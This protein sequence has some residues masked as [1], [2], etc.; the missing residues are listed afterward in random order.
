M[1]EQALGQV[2]RSDSWAGKGELWINPFR[3]NRVGRLDLLPQIDRAIDRFLRFAPV[4]AALFPDMPRTGEIMSSLLPW[5]GSI[6]GVDR[7]FVK[8]DHDLPLAGSVKAR[9]GVHELLVYLEDIAAA[10]GLVEVGGDMTPLIE[11]R[12]HE[13]LAR[14][15]V[16]VASTGNLG[17]AIGIVARAFGIATEVH[18]SAD[19]KHWKRDRLRAIGATVVEHAGDYGEA[20]AKARRIHARSPNA[21]FVDDERSTSLF[22]GYATA[23]AEIARQIADQ[24]IM[25]SDAEPLTVYL[26][27]GVGGAPGGILFGLHRI[28]GNAVRGIF[29]EPVTAACMFLALARAGGTSVSVYDYEWNN[30]TIADGLAVARASDLALEAVGEIAYGAVT[31][32]DDAMLTWMHRAW[33]LAGLKLEPSAA[34]ALAAADQ[35]LAKADDQARQGTHV[36]WTT[37][38]SLIPQVEFER[39]LS[40]PPSSPAKGLRDRMP[41]LNT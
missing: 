7:L 20:V 21:H 31:V 16:I 12:A 9:G 13:R 41:G 2:G 17:L 33:R 27:C 38:G 35:Y 30:K 24:G 32:S 26:P 39:L 40:G 8:A 10:E 29:A 18:V 4:L 5:P 6:R 19:A 1:K 34:A 14:Y 28:Y 25:V 22:V 15:S 36:A 11:A 3:S 37:G 23:G